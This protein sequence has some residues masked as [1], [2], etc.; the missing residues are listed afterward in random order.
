MR[1]RAYGTIVD[2]IG[3]DTGGDFANNDDVE[4]LKRKNDKKERRTRMKK[5]RARRKRR[6]KILGRSRE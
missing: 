2:P 4:D 6:R 1:L 3:S 5:R